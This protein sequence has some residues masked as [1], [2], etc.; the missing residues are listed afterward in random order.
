[1]QPLPIDKRLSQISKRRASTAE[2]DQ[3]VQTCKS[4]FAGW[5]VAHFHSKYRAEFKGTRSYSSVKTVLQG[6]GRSDVPRAE[7][8][9]ASNANA[10]RCPG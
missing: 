7:A 8:S 5:N 3:V 4:G 6:P 1:M 10:R 9:T 2:V